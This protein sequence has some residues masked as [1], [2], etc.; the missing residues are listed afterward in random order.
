MFKLFLLKI[1]FKFVLPQIYRVITLYI[2][3][4]KVYNPK[5]KL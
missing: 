5:I 1:L 3:A 2:I 4:I